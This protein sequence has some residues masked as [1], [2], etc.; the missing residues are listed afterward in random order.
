MCVTLTLCVLCVQTDLHGDCYLNESTSS[1]HN[2]NF[3]FLNS[4]RHNKHSYLGLFRNGT[5]VPGDQA[6]KSQERCWWLT[7]PVS[8][9]DQK[10][11]FKSK[12]E[13]ATSP[14]APTTTTTPAPTTKPLDRREQ[15]RKRV[16]RWCRNLTVILKNP[17]KFQRRC[18]H[19]CAKLTDMIEHPKRALRR[20]LVSF[21]RRRER[22]RKLKKRGGKRRKVTV[23]SEKV[24]KIVQELMPRHEEIFQWQRQVRRCN[25]RR[26]RLEMERCNSRDVR[27]MIRRR[28][29]K[30]Q[31]IQTKKNS[32]PPLTSP[33]PT[34][35]THSTTT[36]RRRH[37][38]HRHRQSSETTQR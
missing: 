31:E 11:A 22:K 18:R 3:Y 21:V 29:K 34:T 16:R 1:N 14:W 19:D 27:R 2:T 26:Q 17:D 32:S 33:S 7:L 10:A 12:R 35:T 13:F 8:E 9:E 38:R 23:D 24:K 4:D 30:R 15:T 25:R 37:S 20:C 5:L 6:R 28:K 36:H